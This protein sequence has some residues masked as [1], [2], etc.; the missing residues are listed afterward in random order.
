M[1]IAGIDFQVLWTIF[2]FL[3]VFNFLPLCIAL[4]SHHPQRGLIAALNL[5][6]LF[7]FALWVAL[8]A[9]A[10][11]GQRNDNVIGRFINNPRY[12]ELFKLGIASFAAFGMGAT[13]GELGIA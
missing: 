1:T 6:S 10:I 12:R 2:V 3:V 4:V 11:G 5:L 13:M 7:S 9:W 8:M